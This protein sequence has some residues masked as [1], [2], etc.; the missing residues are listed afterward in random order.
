M[1]SYAELLVGMVY[2]AMAGYIMYLQHQLKKAHK[3]GEFLTMVLH[4]M[5][6]GNVIIERTED[7][8]KVMRPATDTN[9]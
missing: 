1:I 9:E 8:I 3:A 4:D 7:G 2:F 6:S 5:A